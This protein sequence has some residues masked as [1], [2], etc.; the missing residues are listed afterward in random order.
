MRAQA[1]AADLP[2]FK[3]NVAFVGTKAFWRDVADSPNNH[4]YHWNSN[5]E[6]YTLIGEAMGRAMIRLL[7]PAS[8]P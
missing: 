5:A 3:G 6:T 4:G 8:P 2:E 7:S 1:A